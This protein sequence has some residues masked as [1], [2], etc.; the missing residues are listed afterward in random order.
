ML[1]LASSSERRC[2][3][4]SW[5]G[6]PF[7]VIESKIDERKIVADN[8]EV[9]VK[10]LA[11][12]KAKAVANKVKPSI[13]NFASRRRLIQ[14]FREPVVTEGD[15]R[16]GRSISRVSSGL[17]IGADTV[18][19]IDGEI[20][21]KPK[22]TKDAVR[23]LRKLSGRTHAVYTGL[24]VV[25]VS[26]PGLGKR[27]TRSLKSVSAVEK[28]KVTFR[29]LSDKEIKDY[30]ATGEPLDKGGGYA[31]QMG[32]AGFVKKV[33]GSYTNVVGLPLVTLVGLL[34]KQGYSV[35]K[36]VSQ[37]VFEKTGYTS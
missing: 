20:I 3:L 33:C 23:I 26:R 12:V 10:R 14:P 7:Q 6:V 11:L 22:D 4:L 27:K 28:T 32:A 17:V 9:L 15:T 31:I 1:T 8:P 37:I 34:K 16:D 36:N 21:G 19:A 25:R 5:F 24:A 13:H 30:V 35:G 29:K 18:V 2:A